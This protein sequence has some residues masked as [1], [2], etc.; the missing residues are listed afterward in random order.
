MSRSLA[1]SRS[2]GI[3]LATLALGLVTMSGG[4][5]AA[6]PMDV[7]PG[8]TPITPDP[9]VVDPRP[10]AWDRIVVGSDG[11]TLDIHFWM[12]IEEC[13]GLHSVTVSPTNT[14]IDVALAS[15][16]PA[17]MAPGTACIE[18]AQP[19]VTTVTLDQP[20]ISQLVE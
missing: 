11:R 20:L 4:V 18:I 16:T 12:G 2:L 5:A 9:T 17:D 19:Y 15:G 6:D 10:H 8:V 13:N 3:S 7:G 1:P 14:G